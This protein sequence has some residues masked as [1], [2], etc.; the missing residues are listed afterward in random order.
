MKKQSFFLLEIF[1]AFIIISLCYC[2]TIKSFFYF[3][4]SNIKILE[5]LE[6]ERI[7]DHTFYEIMKN[8]Y[9]M[10]AADFN[11]L[12][13]DKYNPSSFSFN[14]YILNIEPISSFSIKELIQYG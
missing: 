2:V 6:S 4:R 7:A 8:I 11:K 14:D 12:S 3:Y 9:E 13:H 1:I 5:E 10:K